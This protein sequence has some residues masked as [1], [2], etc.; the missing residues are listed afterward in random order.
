MTEDEQRRPFGGVLAVA[1]ARYG[2]CL[3][4]CRL[5][6]GRLV[7]ASKKA[8]QAAAQQSHPRRTPVLQ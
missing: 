6:E 2:R 7:A 5:R 8:G 3:R 4:I 1:K